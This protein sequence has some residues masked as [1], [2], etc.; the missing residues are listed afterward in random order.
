[1]RAESSY[2]ATLCGQEDYQE[3]TVR[4]TLRTNEAGASV[5]ELA[6]AL[7]VALMLLLGVADA[8]RYMATMQG[9]STASREAARYGTATG[10]NDSGHVR[11]TDCDA[12]RDRAQA[13]TPFELN[14]A[15]IVVAYDSGPATAFSG[16][17]PIGGPYPDPDSI[18]SGDRIV[19]TVTTTFESTLPFVGQY[20]NGEISSTDHR[21]IRK[22]EL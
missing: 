11:Y 4:S 18:T 3:K 9:V 7:P 1:M 17:C 15:D 20:F 10:V 21:T 2:C 12:I 6:L 13:S 14:D 5:V 19:V 16:W 22:S 8:A